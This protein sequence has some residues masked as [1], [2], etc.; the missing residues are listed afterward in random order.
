MSKRV[1]KLPCCVAIAIVF[2]ALILIAPCAAQQLENDKISLSVNSKD[3]SYQL[4]LRG[5]QPIFTSCVAAQINHVWLRSSDY[6]RH[7]TSE[8]R[9]ED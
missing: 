1:H 9:V 4:A 5:G 8:S 3:G 7:V 2:E 6:P